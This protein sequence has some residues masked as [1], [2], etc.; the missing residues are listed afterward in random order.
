VFNAVWS[1]EFCAYLRWVSKGSADGVH[2]RLSFYL[3]SKSDVIDNYWWEKIWTIKF[4][5]LKVFF[6]Q[7]IC[8]GIV[9]PCFFSWQR[10][11]V[12][13]TLFGIGPFW[14]WFLNFIVSIFG[15]FF[16]NFC[17]TF[18]MNV[19]NIIPEPMSVI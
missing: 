3:A 16:C 17:A 11:A 6:N 7:W 10:K 8:C 4:P 18:S 1:K 2:Y 15:T 13:N 5:I 19:F 14:S 9:C 12:F